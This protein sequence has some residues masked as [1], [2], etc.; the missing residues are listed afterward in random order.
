VKIHVR[1]EGRY[2]PALRGTFVY[3]DPYTVFDYSG[4][5]PLFNVA[6]NTP[7]RDPVLEKLQQPFVGNGIEGSYD[8]LPTSRTCPKKC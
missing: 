3:F 8:T 7:V 4:V 1:E 2:A 6:K 5:Q